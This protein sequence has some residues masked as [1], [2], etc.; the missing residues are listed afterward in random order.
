[1]SPPN[2]VRPFFFHFFKWAQTPTVLALLGKTWQPF[3]GSGYLIVLALLIM[4]TLLS[5]VFIALPIVAIARRRAEPARGRWLRPTVY[6]ASLGF[7]F[8]LVEVGLIQRFMLFLDHSAQAFSVV[9]FGLLAFSGIGSVFSTRVP[10]RAA[11][12]ALVL[13][14]ALYPVLLSTTFAAFIGGGLPLRILVTLILVAPL[15]ALMGMPFPLGLRV[16]GETRPRWLPVAWG[17]NGF[18]SVIGAVLAAVIGLSWGLG[19]VLAAGAVAYL[20]ALSAVWGRA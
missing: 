10:W 19:S 4:V 6:F 18:T 5:L 9:L 7:G 16:L 15:G 8:L 13:A 1:V 17:V 2:D 3:G 11:L 20:I 14:I 12:G